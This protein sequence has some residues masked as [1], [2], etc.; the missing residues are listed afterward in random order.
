MSLYMQKSTTNAIKQTDFGQ[1]IQNKNVN[2]L[3]LRWPHTIIAMVTLS[4]VDL[5]GG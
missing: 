1:H 4:T 3:E 5:V 2:Q